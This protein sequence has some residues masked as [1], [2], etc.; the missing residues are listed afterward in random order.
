MHASSLPKPRSP[1]RPAD[2]DLNFLSP[3]SREI[4]KRVNLHQ[5]NY[6]HGFDPARPFKADFCHLSCCPYTNEES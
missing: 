4:P 2:L 1:S 5:T 3:P 6:Q